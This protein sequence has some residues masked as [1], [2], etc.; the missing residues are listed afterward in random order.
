MPLPTLANVVPYFR[1]YPLTGHGPDMAKSTPMTLS[2]HRASRPSARRNAAC[3]K[4]NFLQG[5]ADAGFRPIG[6][7]IWS[8]LGT[9]VAPWR[10]MTRS[11]PTAPPRKPYRGGAPVGHPKPRQ[12]VVPTPGAA[13]VSRRHEPLGDAASVA[14]DRAGARAV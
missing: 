4:L 2:G 6:T 13:A 7:R 11:F 3:P 9:G 1:Y 8:A 5:S 10:S 14:H 12:A